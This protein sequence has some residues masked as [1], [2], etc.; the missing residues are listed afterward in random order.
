VST[1]VRPKFRA[2][3][4]QEPVVGCT[5]GT[6]TGVDGTIGYEAPVY[7]QTV[8]LVSLFKRVE[9]ETKPSKTLWF[10]GVVY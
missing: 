4:D 2:K 1:E 8:S 5:G 6:Y 9:V 3:V 10:W 7:G